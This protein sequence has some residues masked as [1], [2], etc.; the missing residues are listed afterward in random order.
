MGLGFESFVNLYDLTK[1]QGPP[2]PTAFHRP[3]MGPRLDR[4]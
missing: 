3:R 1:V 2:S 4:A